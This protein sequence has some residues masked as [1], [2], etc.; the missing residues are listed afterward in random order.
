MQ[1]APFSN[2]LWCVIVYAALLLAPAVSVPGCGGKEPANQD[3]A[4]PMDAAEEWEATHFT[5]DA[6]ADRFWGPTPFEVH[7]SATYKNESGPVRWEWQF[8][9]GS[10]GSTEQNPVHTYTKPGLYQAGC[11]GI[12]GTGDRDGGAVTVRALN[13]EEV[14]KMKAKE[15][16]AAARELQ[17]APAQS[18]PPPP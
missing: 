1:R 12:D 6:D 3:Q 8:G 11:A 5:V 13:D 10:E 9:D 14:A 15:E 18:P 2:P 4:E 7:F 16:E 17:K